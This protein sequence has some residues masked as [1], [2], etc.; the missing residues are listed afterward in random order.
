MRFNKIM[1]ELY[2]RDM[3]RFF[4]SH[5]IGVDFI[6]FDK[7]RAY[8]RLYPVPVQSREAWE[9]MRSR[10]MDIILNDEE[11]WKYALRELGVKI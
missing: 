4:Y 8:V 1:R 10:I 2:I 3:I 7:S 5:D 9:R 11:S 6:S